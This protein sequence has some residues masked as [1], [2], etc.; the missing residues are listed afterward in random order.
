MA[1]LQAMLGKSDLVPLSTVGAAQDNGQHRP[2]PIEPGASIGVEMVSGDLSV[3][4]TGT[5]TYLDGHRFLAFGHPMG[6]LGDIHMPVTEAYVYNIYPSAQNPFKLAG[7]MG[8]IGELSSDRSYAVGG[9]LGVHAPTVPVTIHVHDPSHQ[10]DRTLHLKVFDHPLMTSSLISIVAADALHPLTPTLGPETAHITYHLDVDQDNDPVSFSTTQSSND[11]ED[12]VSGD[13]AGLLQKVT[14]NEFEP[15]HLKHLTIDIQ[16]SPGRRTAVIQKVFSDKSRYAPGEVMKVGVQLKPFNGPSRVRTFEVP[17]PPDAE[18]GA[19]KL[20]LS[21]GSELAAVRKK[22]SVTEP[23]PWSLADV[24]RQIGESERSDELVLTA[25]FGSNGA[26]VG[27][28]RYPFLPTSL[29][30]LASAV[31]SSALLPEKDVATYRQTVPWVVNGSQILGLEIEVKNNVGF[32]PAALLPEAREGKPAPSGLPT[33]TPVVHSVAIVIPESGPDTKVLPSS[34][35]RWLLSEP[36]FLGRG[37]LDSVR[38]SDNGS[39]ALGPAEGTEAGDE[40]RVGWSL[41]ASREGTVVGYGPPARVVIHR[42]GTTEEHALPG[43]AVT[44]VAMDAH[45]VVW[46][47]TCR[48]ARVYRIAP[49]GAPSVVMQSDD[50]YV[51]CL[52]AAADG[53]VYAGTGQPGAVYRLPHGEHGA[54]WIETPEAHVR[55][56]ALAPGGGLYLGT[57]NRGVIYLAQGG[58]LTPIYST[59]YG[60]VDGLLVDGPGLWAASGKSVYHLTSVEPVDVT[61]VALRTGPILGLAQGDGRVYAGTMDGR[62]YDV[63]GETPELVLDTRTGPVTALATVPGEVLA[64][65][66]SPPTVTT[67]SSHVAPQGRWTSPVL[68]AG[69][70]SR[71]GTVRWTADLPGG[72]SV[73][74]SSRSGD[75]AEPDASWGPWTPTAQQD[76]VTAIG[77]APG[78]YLQLAV[79]MTATTASPTVSGLSVYYAP[80]GQEPR[81]AVTSPGV[82]EAWSGK[83]RIAWKIEQGNREDMVFD[84][85]ASTE[86]DQIWQAVVTHHHAIL[87]EHGLVPDEKPGVVPE[88]GVEWDTR[89]WPDGVYRI[90]VKARSGDDIGTF[91]SPPVTVVNHRPAIEVKTVQS[92]DHAV[93][94]EGIARATLVP[95]LEVAY[96][97]EGGEWH[98]AH[99]RN[100]LFDAPIQPFSIDEGYDKKRPAYI[101]IRATDEAGNV[102]LIHK[103][104]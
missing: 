28:E 66:T 86:K 49:G 102:N 4:A 26:L 79:A 84:I 40:D 13:V 100:G 75:T 70:L 93:R 64:L 95:V 94:V 67:L 31:N 52:L 20:A 3:A 17:I 50:Q 46:A 104:L 63:D 48:P 2:G 54:R 69:T 101:E 80:L 8:E 15:T 18:K 96:R 81:L 87:K 25:Q 103:G 62:I 98:L 47:A 57:G 91:L 10:E 38:V 72:A 97:L 42:G 45:G 61:A 9:T 55:A 23:G 24:Y 78:R 39:L 44:A 90:R 41:G 83:H 12:A 92:N 89:E 35:R 11:I 21:G 65:H 82:G 71:W 51:W 43:A 76:G 30:E 14:D 19:V 58:R 5:L 32:K 34:T 7:Q 16:L 85:Q 22:L 33:P 1:M 99:P 88:D 59:D 68:D 37:V 36:G 56:L 77:S 74:V 60:S 73:A 53:D 29:Q 27:A 6:Q